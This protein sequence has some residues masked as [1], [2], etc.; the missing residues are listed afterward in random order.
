MF[1]L[2]SDITIGKFRFS[3]VHEVRINRTIH[4]TIETATIKIP[5]IA[6]VVRND[7][8]IPGS[9][10]TGNQF[11]DGDPVTIKLGYN[12]DLKTEFVGFVKRRNMN[13]PL[14]VEC[15]GYSW[16]L[17]KNKI[18]N[19][20]KSISV[21]DL[22]NAALQDIDPNYPITIQC[23]ASVVLNNVEANSITGLELINN[24]S[25]YSDG[26]LHCFFIKPGVLW[27]GYIYAPYSQ[28]KNPFSNI[29][30]VQYRLG[31]NAINNNS[32]HLRQP[33]TEP[34]EVKYSKRLSTGETLVES[35]NAFQSPNYTYSHI[36]NHIPD[37]PTLKDM[38]NEKA[39]LLNYSGYEGYLQ[40]FLQ[41]L[42][43]PGAT[44]Y[45]S[46]SRY[47]ENNGSYLVE[48]T[49]VIFGINGARRILEIGPRLGVE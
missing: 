5:S 47:P 44:A 14:E 4:S 13:M 43:Q 31:Y 48:S 7:K 28:N 41:P 10:I 49:E 46:D 24:I 34:V 23:D 33:L 2:N 27:Y 26:T 16:L 35:S 19:F 29:D 36:L 45:I 21:K 39:F 1:V 37:A 11:K 32:L 12:G 38:A 6:K 40:A 3:G 15:E 17:R 42:T 25:K 9:I 22:L 18:E 20:W 30:A 8:V